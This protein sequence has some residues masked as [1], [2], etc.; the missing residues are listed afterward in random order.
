MLLN[1][2]EF[3]KFLDF[4]LYWFQV[5]HKFIYFLWKTSLQK[6]GE[7]GREREIFSHLFHSKK[8]PQWKQPRWPK[9]RISHEG[10]DAPGPGSSLL[11][12]HNKRRELIKSEEAWHKLVPVRH[13]RW[14]CSLVSHWAAPWYLIYNIMVRKDTWN[15]WIEFVKF[16]FVA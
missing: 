8:E 5:F 4:C 10:E 14:K 6:E 11:P 2:H 1:F 15:S 13:R 16:C 12:P 7:T 3:V 9:A